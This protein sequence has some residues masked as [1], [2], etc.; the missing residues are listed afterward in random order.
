MSFHACN[1]QEDASAP[2]L[3]YVAYPY[4]V[5]DQSLRTF[6][7]QWQDIFYLKKMFFD[8]NID[9][10]SPHIITQFIAHYQYLDYP[11]KEVQRERTD[12][13]IKHK[14]GHQTR[15]ATK[16]VFRA[17]QQSAKKTMVRART[18]TQI[19]LIRRPFFFET[20]VFFKTKQPTEKKQSFWGETRE[21]ILFAS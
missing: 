20:R 4:Q 16:R 21:K 6:V 10:A 9:L 17:R 19:V 7:H 2:Y 5:L 3:Q 13:S 8:E 11:F 18:H 1:H 12:P 14:F 15:T